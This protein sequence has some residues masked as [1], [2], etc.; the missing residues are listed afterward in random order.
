MLAIGSSKIH[1]KIT[2]VYKCHDIR[3]EV[4]TAQVI[5][6]MLSKFGGRTNG[7]SPAAAKI[8]AMQSY[9]SS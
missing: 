2:S 8:L 6:S 7:D 3:L 5:L 1:P 4:V 9:L